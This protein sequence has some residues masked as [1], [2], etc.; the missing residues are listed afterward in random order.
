MEPDLDLADNDENITAGVDLARRASTSSIDSLKE[1]EEFETS[2]YLAPLSSLGSNSKPNRIPTSIPGGGVGSFRHRGTAS[3]SGSR[4]VRI[5]ET[6]ERHDSPSSEQPRRRIRVL[7]EQA[8]LPWRL[9]RLIMAGSALAMAS[10]GALIIALCLYMTVRQWSRAH[11]RRMMC[12]Y[13][14]APLIDAAAL[15]LP[16][17]RVVVADDGD[18]LDGLSLGAIVSNKLTG[19]CSGLEWWVILLLARAVGAHGHIKVLVGEQLA[20]LPGLGWLLCLLECPPHGHAFDAPA[21]L[22]LRRCMISFAED[23]VSTGVPYL[24]LQFPEGGGIN[25]ASLSSSQSFARRE[26]R[27]ILNHL[28]LPHTPQ[29][30]ACI[31]GLYTAHPVIYDITMAPEGYNGEVPVKETMSWLSFMSLMTEP[32]EVHVRIKRYSMGEVLGNAHWLDDRW[33]EKERLLS[34]FM[35]NGGFPREKRGFTTRR[36]LD[37]RAHMSRFEGGAL[38]LV[39]LSLVPLA[40]PLFTPLIIIVACF[41]IGWRTFISAASKILGFIPFF[42]RRNQS[43]TLEDE[44]DDPH[45]VCNSTSSTPWWF[46]PSTPLNTPATRFLVNMGRGSMGA[47]SGQR[48]GLRDA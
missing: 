25:K 7:G 16:R 1:N 4:T 42:G 41:A 28:L 34:F 48:R 12:S 19:R 5:S 38:A 8:S 43:G 47:A 29:L 33:V 45:A 39:R 44:D 22:A 26:G 15:L 10:T 30:A 14:A 11:Y 18:M 20:H 32:F 2:S 31:D 17:A 6:V 23:S 13:V 9:P 27:P 36:V 3:G 35:L 40:L 24:F 21:G 46:G 37:T